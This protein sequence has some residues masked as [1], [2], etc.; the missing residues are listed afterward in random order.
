MYE[1][2]LSRLDSIAG[3]LGLRSEE[4]KVRKGINPW[5]YAGGFIAQLPNEIKEEEERKGSF[6]TMKTDDSRGNEGETWLEKGEL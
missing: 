6:E 2:L 4:A 1:T 3:V 5:G